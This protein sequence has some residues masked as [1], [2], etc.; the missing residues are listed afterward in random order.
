M[1]EKITLPSGATLEVSLSPFHIGRTMYQ[2]VAEELKQ[3]RVSDKDEIGAGFFKDLFCS[4][5]SSKKIEDAVWEC[6]KRATYNSLRITMDTFEPA[7]ARQ[8]YMMACYEVARVNIEPFT[9]SL[10][11]Q[12]AQ[13]LEKTRSVLS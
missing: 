1:K 4:A 5:L 9:K 3:M 7:E 10:S 13:A 11:A 2:A 6:M 12:F 8:D